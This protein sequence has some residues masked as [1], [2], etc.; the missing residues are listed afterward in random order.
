MSNNRFYVYVYYDPRTGSPFY[1]GK[2]C[3]NRDVRHVS[4][5]KRWDGKKARRKNNRN[6]QF[7]KEMLDEGFQPN[8]ERVADH[9]TNEEACLKEKETIAFF[10]RVDKGGSLF[11]MTDGG[12]GLCPL[13][14]KRGV[15]LEGRK[16]LSEARVRLL[17]ERPELNPMAGRSHSEKSRRLMSERHHDCSGKRNA[18]AKRFTIEAPDGTIHMVEGALI[19]FCSDHDLEYTTLL[20]TLT[21]GCAPGRGRTKGWRML[22]AESLRQFGNFISGEEK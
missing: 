1:V 5:A 4:D 14:Y 3:G 20:K 16:K 12:E 6:L 18:R 22:S 10:G 15:S 2:G 21:T 13:G 9:L 7:I 8:I 17:A 19:P 11:N